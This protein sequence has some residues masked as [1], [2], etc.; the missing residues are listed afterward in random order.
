[1]QEDILPQ[2]WLICSSL[3]DVRH[4]IEQALIE[5]FSTRYIVYNGKHLIAYLITQLIQSAIKK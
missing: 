4:N 5:A 1:M 3:D 2:N